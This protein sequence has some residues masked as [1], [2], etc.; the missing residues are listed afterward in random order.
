MQM[1]H[2]IAEAGQIDLVRLYERQHGGFGG[3]DNVQQMM[4]LGHRQFGHL[5]YMAMPDHPAITGESQT[6]STT[7]A[8]NTTPIILPEDRATG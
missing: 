6:F 1:R 5:P 3:G 7:D 2:N 8:Y 4:A